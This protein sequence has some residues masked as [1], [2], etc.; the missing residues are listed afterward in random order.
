MSN[1]HSPRDSRVGGGLNKQHLEIIVPD[2]NYVSNNNILEV[3]YRDEG[4]KVALFDPNT[5]VLTS[6]FA[7]SSVNDLQ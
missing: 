1:K 5:K 4:Q 2:N 6:E 3:D 7:E